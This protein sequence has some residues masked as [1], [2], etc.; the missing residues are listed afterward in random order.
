MHTFAFRRRRGRV[1]R[2]SSAAQRLAASC[3]APQTSGRSRGSRLAT[4]VRRSSSS[5][6]LSKSTALKP[7]GLPSRRLVAEGGH[8]NDRGAPVSLAAHL[9]NL[10]PRADRHADVGNDEIDGVAAVV[11]SCGPRHPQE[12]AHAI[13]QLDHL[14]AVVAKRIGYEP[15]HLQ[16]VLRHQNSEGRGRASTRLTAPVRHGLS[17]ASA[18]EGA[19]GSILVLAI[20]HTLHSACLE[21]TLPG[22]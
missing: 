14:V 8:Q 18:L 9:E 7:L 6:R 5:K 15:T 13:G 11:A 17:V 4:A 3:L 20:M 16:V 1:A 10:K 12:G 2:R 22:S 21:R 19:S